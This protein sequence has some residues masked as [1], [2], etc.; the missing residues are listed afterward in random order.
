MA[1]EDSGTNE[2]DYA[3]L[4]GLSKIDATTAQAAIDPA[5]MELADWLASARELAEAARGA[6][7]R[8]RHALYAAI[9]RAYDFSLA[10]Q[11]APEDFAELVTDS[12][13]TVQ[14]RAPMTPVVKLV[15]GAE[16]D[17]TRLTEFATALSHAQR[18]GLAQGALGDYLRSAPGGL[19]GVVTQERR[20]KREDSGELIAP[21]RDTPR[22]ALAR[23]LRNLEHFALDSVSAQ[24]SEF[25]LLVARR[26]PSGEVVL[27]GEVAD[28]VPLLERAARKLL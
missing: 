6:E 28:D 24:G 14:D 25:T 1:L 17:K 9:G 3:S 11:D 27:L 23:K 16:Y 5:E 19:K 13:L 8:T 7:H 20:L 21:A 4:A 2:R 18:I 22:E 15:F 26:L 10:A 12:G